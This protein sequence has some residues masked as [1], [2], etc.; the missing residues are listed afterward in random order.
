M[1]TNSSLNSTII[2]NP[3]C[4]GNPNA[5]L[6]VT[7]NYNFD[8]NSSGQYNSKLVGVFYDGA[9]WQIYNEDGST[10]ALGRAFNVLVVKP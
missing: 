2:Y 9:H 8:T 4:D 7:H 10:M 6:L 5:I 1:S 3:V